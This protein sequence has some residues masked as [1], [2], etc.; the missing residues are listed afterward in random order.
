M[1]F[2]RLNKSIYFIKINLNFIKNSINFKKKGVC[3][4]LFSLNI[5]IHLI[6]KRNLELLKGNVL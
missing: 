5:N 6:F 3:N 4:I 2:N 1:N